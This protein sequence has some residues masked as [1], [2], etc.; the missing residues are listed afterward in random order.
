MAM[1]TPIRA[2]AVALALPLLGAAA[3]PAQQLVAP[4]EGNRSDFREWQPNQ[5]EV[6]SREKAAGI[7]ASPEQQQATQ[8]ALDQLNQELTDTNQ[9]LQG[10]LRLLD[11]PRTGQ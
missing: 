3:A 6:Q 9:K 5:G 2:A 4:D 10:E 8:E 7:E 1:K 11:G